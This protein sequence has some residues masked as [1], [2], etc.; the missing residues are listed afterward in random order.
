M[1]IQSPGGNNAEYYRNRKGWFSLNVQTISS[2]DLKILDIVCR[3]PGSV[4]DQ[5]IFNNSLVKTRFENGEFQDFC[6]VGDQG[7]ANT[8]FLATPLMNPNTPIEQLYNESC[9]RTRNCVERK[10]GVLKRR[11]PCLS[12]GM[13]FKKLDRVQI[14]IVACAVLHN[15]VIDAHDREPPMD[16]ELREQI[17]R[18]VEGFDIAIEN[19]DGSQRNVNQIRNDLLN[20]Y[21]PQLL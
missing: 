4:H 10:Y 16:P 20:H 6:L 9:I 19:N 1:K 7:Y 8:R 17:E 15:I 14:V 13:Q 18:S 21:F 12:K 2:A 11:F 5:T 3:W